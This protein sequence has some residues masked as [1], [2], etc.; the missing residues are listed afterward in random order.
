M[1]VL[2]ISWVLLEIELVV[3]VAKDLDCAEGISTWPMMPARDFPPPP[4][5][6]FS[7]RGPAAALFGMTE[8]WSYTKYDAHTTAQ[9]RSTKL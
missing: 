4:P 8:I 7:L 9:S 6:T 5:P 3:G 2:E 1:L